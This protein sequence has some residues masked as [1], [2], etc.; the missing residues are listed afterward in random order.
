MYVA[1]Y[2]FVELKGDTIHKVLK[3]TLHGKIFLAA[4]PRE[5]AENPRSHWPP[6]VA[7]IILSLQV[8]DSRRNLLWGEQHE[9]NVQLCPY[10]SHD[11]SLS[12]WGDT[13]IYYYYCTKES[14]WTQSYMAAMNEHTCVKHICHSLKSVLHRQHFAFCKWWTEFVHVFIS[15]ITITKQL[16]I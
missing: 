1:C 9:D 11:Y 3:N 13:E 8:F 2:E 16:I 15:L 6:H 4:K 14:M 5:G 10:S 7:V 12:T